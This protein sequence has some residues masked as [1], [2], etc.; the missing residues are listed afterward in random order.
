MVNF[1]LQYQ[2]TANRTDVLGIAFPM[3]TDGIGGVL[4]QSENLAALRDGVI[5]LI[6]TPRG[7]RVMR[8]DFGTD[9]KQ[10]LFDPMD[11]MSIENLKSQIAQTI[12]KYEPRVVVKQLEVLPQEEQNTLR[13][14]LSISTKNDLLTT[15][16]VALTV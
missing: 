3:R 14:T 6:M 15:T 11:P 4:T 8:P 10:T 12:A 5:Q 2:K 16:N 9:L 13:I 7:A 1:N